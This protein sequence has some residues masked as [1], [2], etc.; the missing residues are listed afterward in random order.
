MGTSSSY[1]GSGSK[2]AKD[3][4]EGLGSWLDALPEQKP[5]EQQGDGTE[6]SP[7]VIPPESLAPAISL[8]S[9]TLKRTRSSG[10][11]VGGGT[12]S[13]TSKQQKKSNGSRKGGG[14]QRSV[15]RSAVTAGRAASAAYAFSKEDRETL[16]KLGLSYDELRGLTDPLE[17]ISRIVEAA[18]GSQDSTIEDHEQRMVAAEVAEWVI[19]QSEQGET[20]DPQDIT[21]KSIAIV[22]AEVITSETGEM[23][24]KGERPEWATELAE[25]QIYEAAE[26][27]ADK[28][29]LSIN[30][31]T[32]SQFSKAIES[33][34]ETLRKIYRS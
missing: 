3:L 1:S 10:G 23:L 9:P 24:R 8:L 25:G 18:C 31:A 32:A 15:H 19:K 11:G 14:A 4:R 28:A 6:T 7:Y 34:I 29:E 2:P 20:P 17:L 26:A 12:S 16:S 30:G 27:L 33:G 21:R 5:S 22:I 13:G